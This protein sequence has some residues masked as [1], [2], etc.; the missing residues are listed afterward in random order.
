MNSTTIYA[1]YLSNLQLFPVC[2][3]LGIT[4]YKSYFLSLDEEEEESLDYPELFTFF[5]YFDN[6]DNEFE[7]KN[8]FLQKLLKESLPS[9][10]EDY[11]IPNTKNVDEKYQYIIKTSIIYVRG[12]EDKSLRIEIFDQPKN[13]MFQFYQDFSQSQRFPLNYIDKSRCLLETGVEFS[14]FITKS[15]YEKY[16][17]PIFQ[18]KNS[19]M[20]RNLD[21]PCS[22]DESLYNSWTMALKQ[23]CDKGI[24]GIRKDNV[25][26]DRVKKIVEVINN[27]Q[28]VEL[29]KQ[30]TEN[31]KQISMFFRETYFKKCNALNNSIKEED[32]FFF[33]DITLL[34]DDVKVGNIY[35]QKSIN[36]SGVTDVVFHI[37]FNSKQGLIDLA[38]FNERFKNQYIVFP[39]VAFIVTYKRQFKEFLQMDLM[40][41][42]LT[43]AKW[44]S[45]RKNIYMSFTNKEKSKRMKIIEN[46]AYLTSLK[47][48]YNL[49]ET[50][51]YLKQYILN[52]DDEIISSVPSYSMLVREIQEGEED[53]EL[54][55]S[56]IYKPYFMSSSNIVIDD[57][58]FNKKNTLYPVNYLNDEIVMIRYVANEFIDLDVIEPV[59]KK[60]LNEPKIKHNINFWQYYFIIKVFYENEHD[61]YYIRAINVA[62]YSQAMRQCDEESANVE[63]IYY[64]AEYIPINEFKI[65]SEIVNGT[66]LNYQETYEIHYT[67]KEALENCLF[68]NSSSVG[69]LIIHKLR[70]KNQALLLDLNRIMN[71]G[72]KMKYLLTRVIVLKKNIM[73]PITIEGEEVMEL[74]ETD[75][76]IPKEKR[77]VQLARLISEQ[78]YD[79]ELTTMV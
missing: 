14:F 58:L 71:K 45:I 65:L 61:D 79:D 37:T 70:I 18:G 1:Q 78:F 77:I 42:P 28:I 13:K 50:E 73:K 52:I 12:V 53:E 74:I 16:I 3:F 68:T 39:E 44:K 63:K 46:A 31:K 20:T 21:F 59:F 38:A 23:F 43:I 56:H 11:D 19:Q 41:K 34:T 66:V 29:E 24:F 7:M 9:Q 75:D 2:V 62:L 49:N 27:C 64:R 33:N 4:F 30:R 6:L 54:K 36:S 17:S 15:M 32:V 48:V 57:V 51:E 26:L 76:Y 67:K 55:L 35:R 22:L 25:L 69:K 72:L 60:Y 5:E 47:T 8:Q 10:I 40:E